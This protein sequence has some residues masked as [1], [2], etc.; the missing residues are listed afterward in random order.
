MGRA[1]EA[2]GSRRVC[3]WVSKWVI[4]RDTCSH[5]FRDCWK[6]RPE[7]CNA[8]LTHYLEMKLV[9]FGLV[10]LLLSY[11][12]ICSPQ[13]LL[14]AIQSPVK[15]KSLTSGCLSTWQF[16]LYNKSN[17]DLSEILRTGL[18][19]LHCLSFSYLNITRTMCNWRRG[20][21]WHHPCRLHSISCYCSLFTQISAWLHCC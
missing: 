18:P 9:D 10:S 16:N 4:L 8:S 1:S 7:T 12:M 14:P 11:G 20:L 15:N 13:R 21:I 17:D 3:L 5:F 2:Y 6:L 19:K